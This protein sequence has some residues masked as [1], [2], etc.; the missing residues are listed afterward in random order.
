MPPAEALEDY[1]DLVAAVE[2]TADALGIRIIVEGYRPPDDVR[3][4]HF[5]VTPDPGVIE[6][7]V[8]PASDWR[9]L[10]E[11]TT[12]LYAEA[13]K[14]GLTTEKFML[15]GRHTGTGGGNHFVLGG[16]T[17]ADSPFLRRPDLLR[18]LASV[19]AQPSVAV[20]SVLRDVP[21]SDEPGAARRRSAPRQRLRARARL[22]P[23]ARRPGASGNSAP[24]W[25]VDRA[26]RHLLVDVTG[27]THRAEFCIDKMFPPESSSG[28]RGL[29]ELRA[30]EMPPHE[31]MSLAQQLLLRALVARF[32]RHPYE[33]RLTRW[34]TALHDRFMLPYFIWQDFED[35][36]EEVVR[37]GYRLD[38]GWFLP[39][40]EF[41]FPLAGEMA[42]RGATFTL[43]QALEP[44][45]VLGEEGS[46]GT[47]VRYVDSS[48]ERLQV[49]VTGLVDDRFVVTCNGVPVPLQPTG[50][51]G[52]S[53]AGVRY[54]AWQPSSAL[55]PTIPVHAP[56]T[57]DLVDTWMRRSLGGCQ[58]HVSHPGGLSY[59]RLP[60][61]SYEAESRRLGRFFRLGHTP[62]PMTAERPVPSREFPHTLDLRA[63]P[64]PR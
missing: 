3:L 9:E 42:L 2:D 18:S 33:A 16:A 27:N 37:A 21:R 41:R 49:H 4:K 63:W 14:A 58:Y 61:N 7:N 20:V 40:F 46:V 29:L 48:L 23:P 11:Q 36:I 47:T 24:P 38:A 22:R 35:V 56:L 32:W 50:R 10:D 39:H 43:R 8:Q 1:L 55:H 15:D 51:N 5:L 45:P 54:R 30:F 12:M 6:V 57:F 19:L 13:R 44:W 25:Q 62:G 28:R 64:D 26:L 31:R 34:G 59:D 52:E 17:P 53:V 60:I